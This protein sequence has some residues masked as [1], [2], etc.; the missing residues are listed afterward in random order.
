VHFEDTVVYSRIKKT[1]LIEII[2]K[3]YKIGLIKNIISLSFGVNDVYKVNCQNKSY[4]FRISNVLSY[5]EYTEDDYQT[6]IAFLNFMNKDHNIVNYPIAKSD[7]SFMGEI[8]VPEGIRYF[9]LFNYVDGKPLDHLTNQKAYQYGV[10]LAILHNKLTEFA[11]NSKPVNRFTHN[12]QSLYYDP[13]EFIKEYGMPEDDIDFLTSLEDVIIP[14]ID[15]IRKDTKS[16]GLIHGDYQVRNSHYNDKEDTP[17]IFD[18]DY[19]SFSWRMIDIANFTSATKFFQVSTDNAF[20]SS[21]LEGY[22]KSCQLKSEELASLR[23]FEIAIG[24][25]VMGQVIAKRERNSDRNVKGFL[26]AAVQQLRK[27][28]DELP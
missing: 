15:S 27:F 10:T 20:E 17:I 12:L 13:I 22:N 3:N 26:S 5:W 16:F 7:G 6:E 21:F 19:M 25:S 24:I 11:N 9:I 1:K 28:Y 14:P 8:T 2:E 23:Y 4:I 18:F